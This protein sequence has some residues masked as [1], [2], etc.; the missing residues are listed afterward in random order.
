MKP[1]SEHFMEKAVSALKEPDLQD[2]MEANRAFALLS[3]QATVGDPLL[4]SMR[5]HACKIKDHVLDCL[6]DYLSQYEKQAK[7]NGIQV[8]WAETVDDAQNT[9]QTICRKADARMAICGKSMIAAEM[10][11]AD[12]LKEIGVERYETDLG[13][14]ILQLA[15][16]EPPSHVNGPA[17][18]KSMDQIRDLFY[19]GHR[20]RGLRE[21]RQKTPEELLRDVR[22]ILRDK[23]LSADVGIIGANFLIAETGANVLVSNEGNA[24][25]SALLPRTKIILASIE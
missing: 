14:Y 4:S 22:E 23:F 25:L 11:A 16:D 20:G 18:H 12:A 10:N 19:E 21:T 8:H 24:D 9:I 15:G 13:E 5:D 1:V 7:S 17:I 6:P 3:R 2:A